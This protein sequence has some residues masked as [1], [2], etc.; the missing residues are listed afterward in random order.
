M[1]AYQKL[2]KDILSS[3]VI[4]EPDFDARIVEAWMLVE[5]PFLDH[6]SRPDFIDATLRAFSYAKRA[7]MSANAALAATF[8]LMTFDEADQF[9]ALKARSR[10]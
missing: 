10:A 6:L 8:G 2:I 7:D 5:H 3:A 9:D 1:S 4:N